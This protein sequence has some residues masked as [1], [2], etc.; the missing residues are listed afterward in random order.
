MCNPGCFVGGGQ[1]VIETGGTVQQDGQMYR[2]VQGVTQML[3]VGVLW[4]R[5]TPHTA[6]YW[7]GDQRWGRVSPA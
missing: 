5:K 1:H 7:F 4:D 2:G 3:S 6:D